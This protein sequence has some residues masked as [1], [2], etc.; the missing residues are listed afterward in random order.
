MKAKYTLALLL[1][2]LAS[3]LAAQKFEGLAA[4]ANGMEQLEHVP[5]NISES[6]IQEYGRRNRLSGMQKAGYRF[7]VIDDGWRPRSATRQGNLV[8]DPTRFPHGNESHWRLTCTRAVSCSASTTAR[9]EK[10]A[11][12]CPAGAATSFRTRARTLPGE[13]II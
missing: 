7:I 4:R 11:P 5:S 8:P 12:A 1:L 3:P 2:C 13:S 10:P 6:L 9:D